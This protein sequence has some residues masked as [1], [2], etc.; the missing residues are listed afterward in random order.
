M[1]RKTDRSSVFLLII[2]SLLTITVTEVKSQLPFSGKEMGSEFNRGMELF[3]KEKYPAAIRLLDSY[4]RSEDNSE[5]IKKDEAEY[6]SA[7]SALRLFNTDAE[8][9]M[10]MYISTHPESPR[11]NE[12]RLELGDYFY[13]NKNYRKA[14]VYY[15][16]VNRQQLESDKLPEYF[17]RYGYSS[18]IK[19]DKEKALLMF[20]EIKDIDT[21]YTPPAIYY[22][23]QIAYEDKMYQTAMEGFMRLKDDETFGGVVPFY[24][25]QILYLQKDYDGILEIAPELISS[26]GKERVVELYRFI[27]DAY[28]NKG[29]YAEALPYLEKYSAGAKA[30]AREDKYQLGY[31]Y[32][33]TKEIDKAIKTLLDIGVRSDILSHNIWNIL[34]DCYLQK[35][36]KK[37]AQLAFGE[38]SKLNYDKKIKEESLFNYAKLTYELAYSPFG[39]AIASFQEYIDLYPG[40]ERIQEV[41]DY[42]IG[43]YMQ[44]KSY[45]AALASLDK[46]ANKDSRLEEAYQR[47]AFFRGLELFKNLEIEASIDMFDK[48]LKYEKYNRQIR[49]RAIYWRGEAWYRLA[50]YDKAKSDYEQF[51]GI[52]GS[53]LLSEYNMVRYNLGYSLFN[54]DDY[55]NALNHFKTFESGVTNVRP[56]VLADTKNR[57]ADCYY[58]TMNYPLAISY[59][60]KVI[61]YGNLDADYA[62]FQ[63]GFSLGLM[64]DGKGKVDILTSL[65]QKYPK[66]TF[67][68]NAI[69]ERGRAYIVLEDYARGEADLNSVI[70]TYPSNP[71]VPRAIVQLGL[72]YYNLGENEKAIAQYKKVIENFKS[73][74]EA[75][76]AMTGLKNAYV[77]MNDVESYFAY[78]KTLD[79]YGDV[80]LAAKDSMLYTSGENLYISARYDRATE[81]FK[82][83]LT[84][85]PNGSFRQNAQYYLAECLRSAGNNDEALKYYTAVAAEPNNQ[86]MEQSLIAASSIAFEKEDFASSLDYY[87]R[88]EKAAN[89]DATVLAALKGQLRS[90]YEA[91]NAQKTIIAAG[92]IISFV[93][94]PEELVREANFMSAKANYSINKIDEA[95][96]DFRKVSVEVTSAEG[97]E[98]KFR[99]AE[100]LYKKD[101]VADAEKVITEFIN[102]N[103]P[104]QFWMARIFLLLADISI[105]KGDTLQARA[106]LQSLKDYYSVDND[107]ILDEVKSKLDALTDTKQQPL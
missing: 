47:V 6:Y 92:K 99:V 24:I 29:N 95:L 36:D 43:A 100:L 77:E 67:V 107:G 17:F 60:D 63:K 96:R 52:P 25:V 106:T 56:E 42:L 2:F 93:N 28:Y 57:I 70:S 31:C 87:E 65:I 16:T 74:L 22:F 9:R 53:M 33:K 86:F 32:Y 27:G 85:F 51:M 41:Y 11:I 61:E 5:K 90:A 80:N 68:P 55:S 91:E 66:S 21:E 69:F 34:G 89:T 14:S 30:S 35:G 13:Q 72:L 105:K 3:N 104:H 7:L 59:Y 54:L 62:M 73:T 75:R 26:A 23:S 102:Q 18:Y 1:N 79:G 101:Q 97:A 19:G 82:N 44:L 46:I 50:H 37:R 76:N 84:E 103:T 20:S 88:L 4:V 15:E 58:I 12:A 83:Y 40:S 98:S 10:V 8:Y 45:K 78:V 39:E 48:S 38:A 49:A 71:L 94:V 64:N 81:V